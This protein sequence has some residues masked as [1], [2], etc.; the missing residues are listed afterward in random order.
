MIKRKIKNQLTKGN[1]S[2]LLAIVVST[3]KNN[4]VFTTNQF[5]NGSIN[6]DVCKIALD[7][8]GTII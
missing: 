6:R 8:T 2:E 5:E 4:F 1:W 3:K 7:K